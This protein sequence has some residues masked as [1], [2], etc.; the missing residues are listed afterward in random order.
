MR[1]ILNSQTYQLSSIP[2]SDNPRAEALFAHYP[3]RRLEAE[4]L[5]D[6]LCAISGTTEEMIVKLNPARP[7]NATPSSR[8]RAV[9]RP[10]AH[11]WIL[12]SVRQSTTLS[13][14]GV[15]TPETLA[16]RSEVRSVRPSPS[17]TGTESPPHS[18][19]CETMF[20]MPQGS[21]FAG[22]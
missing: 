11:P 13:G 20:T 18:Y 21:P 17:R 8:S 5:I 2:A 22:R 6:A 4:V 1:L 12:I 15:S 14:R 16:S 7:P 19:E 10:K 9:S 3:V